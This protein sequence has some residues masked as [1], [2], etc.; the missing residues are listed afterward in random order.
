M[1]PPR[2]AALVSILADLNVLVVVRM[3]GDAVLVLGVRVVSRRV[4]VL[5]QRRR[6]EATNAHS[7]SPAT[8]RFTSA[9]YTRPPRPPPPPKTGDPGSLSDMGKPLVAVPAER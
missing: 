4:D 1:R 7:K 9:V 8:G 5:G 6:P 2:V 3:R